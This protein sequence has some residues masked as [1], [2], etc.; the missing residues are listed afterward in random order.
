[1][2]T[3]PG[4]RNH[5][6]RKPATIRRRRGELVQAL[7]SKTGRRSGSASPD[8]ANIRPSPASGTLGGVAAKTREAILRASATG[9]RNHAAMI[10]R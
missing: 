1:V 7:L 8:N 2:I 10:E 9:Q 4:A 5:A 6:D 3:F